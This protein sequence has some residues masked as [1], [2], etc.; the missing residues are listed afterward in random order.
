LVAFMARAHEAGIFQGAA[1][2]GVNGGDVACLR[3]R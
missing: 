2:L 1:A 3:R